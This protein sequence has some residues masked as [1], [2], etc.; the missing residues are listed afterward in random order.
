MV[1]RSPRLHVNKC[2]NIHVAEMVAGEVRA[3]DPFNKLLSAAV[4]VENI[5]RYYMR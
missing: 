3:P 2:L 5:I 1:W 4:R